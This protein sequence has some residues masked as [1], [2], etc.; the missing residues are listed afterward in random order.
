MVF[1]VLFEQSIVAAKAVTLLNLCMQ[2][3][4]YDR[5]LVLPCVLDAVLGYLLRKRCFSIGAKSGLRQTCS[6]AYT[7]GHFKLLHVSCMAQGLVQC[8][9]RWVARGLAAIG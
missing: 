7:S 1:L 6:G 9:R 5:L 2:G 8:S 4:T 3:V